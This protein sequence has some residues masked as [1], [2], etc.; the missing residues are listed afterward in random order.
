[1]P[2]SSAPSV[3]VMKHLRTSVSCVTLCASATSN[4]LK[5]LEN[6]DN[7]D[8]HEPRKPF[9][10]TYQ[11]PL[12]GFEAYHTTLAREVVK[13]EPPPGLPGYIRFA[14]FRT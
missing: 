2:A 10:I 11:Q 1:M 4:K 13:F 3:P 7:E 6:F 12:Q 5:D 14:V 8:D 9:Y